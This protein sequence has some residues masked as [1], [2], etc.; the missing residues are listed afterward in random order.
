[1]LI[2]DFDIGKV[3]AFLNNLKITEKLEIYISFILS[4]RYRAT[5]S[6]NISIKNDFDE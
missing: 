5:T 4:Y 6:Q 3:F 1:M 2:E